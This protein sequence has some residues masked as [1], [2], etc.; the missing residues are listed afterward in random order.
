MSGVTSFIKENLIYGA[1]LVIFLLM[2]ITSFFAF[3]NQYVMQ[4]TERLSSESDGVIDK[5]EGLL[6]NLNL[7]D[8]G[9]RGYALTKNDGLLN[10]FNN[11]AASNKSQLDS[12]RIYLV[13]QSLPTENFEKYAG[14]VTGYIEFCR[15]MISLATLD[16]MEEFQ[17]LLQ[18]D[19]GLGV[20]QTYQGFAADLITHERTR[21]AAAE[22]R[23]AAAVRGNI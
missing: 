3:R 10:P 16:N 1:I 19:R 7:M 15:H 22:S 17:R 23:Y 6:S 18:E 14:A 20:W 5:T 2:I 4:E 13:R 21:K 8:L 9:V 12:I 11:A